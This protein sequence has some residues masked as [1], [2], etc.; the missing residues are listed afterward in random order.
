MKENEQGKSINLQRQ[1]GYKDITG[2][3]FKI[4]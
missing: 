1:Q 2:S 4:K 3:K